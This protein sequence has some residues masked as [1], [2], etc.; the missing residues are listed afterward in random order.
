LSFF[1]TLL[2]EI[3]NHDNYDKLFEGFCKWFLENDPY[4]K[5]Q[6]AC[7]WLW[8][9]WPGRWG[10]DKG[11]DLIFEHKNGEIWAVQAKC[12]A[13]D[14]YV[15]KGD[16][17]KFLSESGRPLIQK[18]LLMATTD[19]LGQNASDVLLSQEKPV[20]SYL[21][22]DF[23]SSGLVFPSKLSELKKA[24]KPLQD[25]RPY[26]LAAIKDVLSG[27]ATQ[28]RGQLIMA[29]G[30]G[31]TIVT[32]RIK[33]RINPQTTLVLLPSLSLL[34]QTL[35]EWTKFA[36]SDFEV[37]C[38]CSDPTVGKRDQEEDIL[39][40]EAGFVVTSDIDEISSFIH[41]DNEKVIFCTYQSSELISIA[42]KKKGI[43]L[44]VCDEAH[45]CAGEADASFTRVLKNDFINA[46]KRLFTTA[47]PRIFSSMVSKNAIAEGIEL[48]GMDDESLFGPIFFQYKFGQAIEDGWLTDYQLVVVAVN[49]ATVQAHIDT[50][51]LLRLKEGSIVEADEL[52]SRLSLIKAMHDYDLRRVISFHSRVQ[53]AS[54]FASE[55]GSLIELVEPEKRPSG[56]L[57]TDHVSGKMLASERRSKI[58]QLKSLH[59]VDR[60]LLTNARCLSEGVDV[61][62]L[63]GVAFIDPRQSQIDI[64]QAVGRALRLSDRKTKG[65]IIVPVFLRPNQDGESALEDSDFKPVWDVL[66]ALR[67]H[68]NSLAEE[69]DSYR[70]N[71]GKRHIRRRQRGISK[72]VFD[73][74]KDVDERFSIALETKLVEM[75]SQ[76]WE[77]WFGELEEYLENN[78]TPPQ[79]PDKRARQSAKFVLADW[80]SQQRTL[81]NNGKLSSD[82]VNR[83]ATLKGWSWNPVKDRLIKNAEL[84]RE[85]CLSNKTWIVPNRKTLFKDVDI[86]S[87]A[88]SIRNSKRTDS[89]SPEVEEIV[90][91]IPGWVWNGVDERVWEIKFE[92]YKAWHLETN[93]HSPPRD[94]MINDCDGLPPFNLGAWLNQQTTRYNQSK[95]GVRPLKDEQIERFETEIRFWHWTNWE[96]SFSGYKYAVEKL[97]RDN[98]N[99]NTV[100]EELPLEIR[101][102][103]RWLSKQRG[104]CQTVNFHKSP[105]LSPKFLKEIE[106]FGFDCD[107][108]SKIWFQGFMELLQYVRQNNT[109]R[110]SQ[111][112]V[113]SNGFALGSWVSK[114]RA[115]QKKNSST[116][117]LQKF[118]LKLLSDQPDWNSNWADF[119][120]VNYKVADDN[121]IGLIK[122]SI[123]GK[124]HLERMIKLALYAG[125]RMH[126]MQKF[127]HINIEKMP[128]IE[129]EAVR[130][131]TD[132]RL[133]PCHPNI[134]GVEPI[135]DF[136]YAALSKAFRDVKP[137][138]LS[139]EIHF[140]SFMLRFH[141]EL[142]RVGLNKDILFMVA[143]GSKKENWT[144]K[145]LEEL[146]ASIKKISYDFE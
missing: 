119:R 23:N 89:L 63:D 7:V 134:L 146:S 34:S 123:T 15:T 2:S 116:H 113:N 100:L 52:A 96:R 81:Q 75:S 117:P 133:I 47:T 40:G 102:V 144:P 99:V 6:V 10:R 92:R 22:E 44:V 78:A 126:E 42:Q 43:D 137:K 64:V 13:A 67:S 62:A 76:S 59:G 77:A 94:L 108:F 28:D 54:S 32:L 109:S 31:K 14:Y 118:Q 139:K 124:D 36:E 68:D 103:G 112:Y 138:G 19:R 107:P 18:R 128:F 50:R 49:E 30:T 53:A 60:G 105:K 142:I 21:L 69:I 115:A 111:E 84:L 90:S 125:L 83:L 70:R 82:R 95:A 26:Q 8:D 106:K 127:R 37:L 57:W 55:L 130:G 104:H 61:P 91:S 73:L 86:A 11:I 132:F 1:L 41:Q 16:V 9:D 114:K 25:Q 48:Y 35:R 45:R 17:D 140:T 71:L 24:T 85:W 131:V 121:S 72:V 27:F 80:C 110:V 20:I 74:P 5:T 87:I 129:I 3:R 120:T 51:E 97:G 98:V 12:Y 65:T 143:N 141:N 136:T 46:R 29:C 135:N 88:K 145:I 33:E 58:Q 56:K 4:W 101:N 66:K 122:D 39:V 79:I 38:V 93:R